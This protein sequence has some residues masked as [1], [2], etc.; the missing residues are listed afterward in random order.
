MSEPV[1]ISK[2]AK[3]ARLEL[4]DKEQASFGPQ[5]AAILDFVEQL[6]ELDTANVEPMTT[7]IDVQNCF[8]DDQP[9]E[10]L[11]AELATR[12][13]AESSE[14]FFLVPPVLGSAG[15]RKS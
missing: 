2:L 14:G 9:A 6:S 8:R 10:S 12:T 4:T 11:G 3:L 5:I 13:A 7:A 15:A 1:N